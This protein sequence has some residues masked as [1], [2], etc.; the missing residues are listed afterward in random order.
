MLSRIVELLRIFS[1]VYVHIILKMDIVMNSKRQPN[2]EGMDISENILNKVICILIRY[3][4]NFSFVT[5]L[6]T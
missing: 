5:K 6:N 3:S 1:D 2:T 4:R